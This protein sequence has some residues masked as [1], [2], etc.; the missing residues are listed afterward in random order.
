VVVR[1]RNDGL[2]VDLVRLGAVAGL[3]S[4]TLGSMY[5]DALESRR[6]THIGPP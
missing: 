4:G 1:V 2:R 3:D 5:F 6:E